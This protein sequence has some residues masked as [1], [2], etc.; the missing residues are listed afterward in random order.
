MLALQTNMIV[1][2]RGVALITIMLV[3]AIL[4]A[5]VSRI[6]LSN[7]IW[8]R[9]VENSAALAQA[10]LASRAAQ[11]WIASILEEDDNNFDA[12]TEVWAQPLP[13]LPAGWGILFGWVEDMQARF[14]LNNLVDAEGKLDTLAMQQFERLLQ[15]LEL[16]PGIAQAVADWIDADSNT[17]GPWGAE[18]VF[19]INLATPYFAANRPFED[20]AELRLVRG[21]DMEIWQKLEP[22]VSALPES[23]GINI[24]TASTQVLAAAVTEWDLA[25]QAILLAEEWTGEMAQQPVED[26]TIVPEQMLGDK[27]KPIPPGLDLGTSY[28]MA[29]TQLS[30]G[31]V[32]YR[33]T[34]LYRRNQGQAVILR[35][36]RE[37]R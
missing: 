34:T 31:N 30:F 17:A 24:N 36:N 7:Q 12:V 27:D 26:M 5:I 2:Q 35:H 21:I 33:M 13:P 19:Y 16:N 15:I 9:Q 10:D 4:T 37:L 8:V 23:T 11:T 20:T 32:A 14:N 18:D 3:V 29:H 22:Y 28:F 25:G 1:R 6:A